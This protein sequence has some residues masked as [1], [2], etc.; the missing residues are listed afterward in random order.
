MDLNDSRVR[1][2]VDIKLG[3]RK[4]PDWKLVATNTIVLTT[5][6]ISAVVVIIAVTARIVHT[7]TNEITRTNIFF[8]KHIWIT[9]TEQSCSVQQILIKIHF[10]WQNN[11]RIIQNNTNSGKTVG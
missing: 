11:L 1:N 10:I 7:E 8:K 4:N 2:F 5:T 6:A 3:T 9:E